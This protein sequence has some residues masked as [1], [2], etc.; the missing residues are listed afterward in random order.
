MVTADAIGLYPSIPYGFGLKAL[1]EALG[2][3]RSKQGPTSDLVKIAT[4]LLQNNYFE[5]NGETKH[6][7][8]L[9]YLI[10]GPLLKKPPSF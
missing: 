7:I 6:Q 2:K 5:F 4:F 9:L 8:Y 1:G 10:V 3:R